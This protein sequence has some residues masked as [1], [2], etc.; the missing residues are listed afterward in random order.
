MA[1]E[2][3]KEIVSNALKQ[4][5]KSDRS[6]TRIL[7][8]SELGLVEMTRKRVRESLSKLYAIHAI[9]AREKDILKALQLSAMK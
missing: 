6:R 2:E 3:S 4:A 8:I 1:N 9:T 7:K 5:L